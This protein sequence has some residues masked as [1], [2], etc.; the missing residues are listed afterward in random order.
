MA[1]GGRPGKIGE[2]HW[3]VLRAIVAERPSA[4]L[5]EIAAEVKRRVGI[6]AHEATIRKTLREAGIGRVR[7]QQQGQRVERPPGEDYGYTEAHRRRGP[8]QRYPSCLTDAQWAQVEDLFERAGGQGRPAQVSRRALVDACCYVVRTGCAWRRLPREFP[9]WPNVYETFRRW[10]AAGA[11][12]R[13]HDRLRGLWRERA[14]RE[15][16]PS[17]AVLDAQSTR[18]SPQGGPSGFDAGKQV[19]GRKR[20]LVV[21]TLGL[22]LAVSVGA[23]N[24][25]D[26]E[27]GLP[28][29]AR[30]AENYPEVATLFV[31]S[32]YAGACASASSTTTASASRWSVTPP[33][34]TVGRWI[35]AV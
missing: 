8:E 7:R 22:L 17:A 15:A 33:T 29:V 32:A 14:G 21:D 23:A 6:A 4:T 10:S 28:A 2:E 24:L 12:E 19:K 20:S 30:A 34:A 1:A 9:P 25:Q 26:R 13:M 16:A 18:G 5:G 35:D 3:E 11:F 27:A 31:D